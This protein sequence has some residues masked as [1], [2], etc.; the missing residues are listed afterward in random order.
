MKKDLLDK[1]TIVIFLAFLIVPGAVF[2]IY[3]AF[4][5]GSFQ[6]LTFDKSENRS[7]AAFPTVTQMATD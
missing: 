6:T 2:Y 5:P 3:C 1:I 7:A 4:N